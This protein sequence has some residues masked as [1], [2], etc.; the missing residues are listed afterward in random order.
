MSVRRPTF[1]NEN[2]FPNLLLRFD[3]DW[4]EREWQKEFVEGCRAHDLRHTFMSFAVALAVASKYW[5]LT[6]RV[7]IYVMLECLGTALLLY[8]QTS[9]RNLYAAQ[10]PKF[11][12]IIRIM[13]ICFCCI[14]MARPEGELAFPVI[15]LTQFTWNPKA[16]WRLVSRGMFLTLQSFGF[17]THFAQ[18]VWLHA[19]ITTIM[20]GFV[21]RRCDLECS[22]N[23]G[24][25]LPL[26]SAVAKFLVTLQ[27]YCPWFNGDDF[28]LRSGNCRQICGGAN[29][30]LLTGIGF[31]LPTLVLVAIE[32]TARIQWACRLF[33]RSFIFPHITTIL[34][35]SLFLL[36]M[37]V[38]LAYVGMSS[39][40][41]VIYAFS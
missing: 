38:V 5:H 11:V 2:L 1:S 39:I 4:T 33:G 20:V 3:D 40:Y 13:R 21:D 15:T 28:L 27:S 7:Y 36:L 30:A 34:F 6:D 35:Y 14:M 17:Q 25:Y 31:V 26:F 8:L 16:V 29:V 32:E 19:I 9:K 22:A 24:F 10:R 18:H 41:S 12:A 23:K 37:Y